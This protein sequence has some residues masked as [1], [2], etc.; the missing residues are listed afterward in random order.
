MLVTESI[1]F[2][3]FF[4][5][6]SIFL[7]KET[8][9]TKRNR[10]FFALFILWRSSS[11]NMVCLLL[12]SSRLGSLVIDVCHPLSQCLFAKFGIRFFL[13][14]SK[15]SRF[16]VWRRD[17]PATLCE[18]NGD[19]STAR[20]KEETTHTHTHKNPNKFPSVCLCL[21]EIP[22]LSAIFVSFVIICEQRRP[23]YAVIDPRRS[24]PWKKNYLIK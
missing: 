11:E 10:T 22:L 5:F 6:L 4:F 15:L 23:R 12:F 1:V 13:S 16:P 9:N 17:W 2:F 18:R 14:C 8:W 7:Q 24:L 20:E 19:T 21:P 3:F